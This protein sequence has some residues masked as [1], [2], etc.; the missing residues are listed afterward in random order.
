MRRQNAES[1][2]DDDDGGDPGCSE[3]GQ[4]GEPDDSRLSRCD[5]RGGHHRGQQAQELHD[6]RHEHSLARTRDPRYGT[7]RLMAGR[8]CAR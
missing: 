5:G 4:N 2:Q 6:D 1:A 7:E 3:T 8:E